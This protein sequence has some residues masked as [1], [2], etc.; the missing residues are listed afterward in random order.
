M[1]ALPGTREVQLKKGYYCN[2][3]LSINTPTDINTT[4]LLFYE[5]GS[6]PLF[7]HQAQQTIVA[8]QVNY[9]NQFVSQF[10]AKM[11]SNPTFL[12]EGEKSQQGC[13]RW[14]LCEHLTPPCCDLTCG[15]LEDCHQN[16]NIDNIPYSLSL[17]HIQYL[18][19]SIIPYLV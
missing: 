2:T 18:P 12:E 19:L 17:L 13:V 8:I 4:C 10:E 5:G 15:G 6:A 14:A 1:V 7:H 9:Q 11:I 16:N 3:Y